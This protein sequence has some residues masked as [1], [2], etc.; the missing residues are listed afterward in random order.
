MNKKI[1]P[2]IAIA[3]ILFAASVLAFFIFKI[4]GAEAPGKTN[5]EKET[6]QKIV[7]E[8]N[9]TAENKEVFSEDLTKDWLEYKNYKYG[10]K[11]KFSRVMAV[12]DKNLDDVVISLPIASDV[13]IPFEIKI[14]PTGENYDLDTVL[15]KALAKDLEGG[16]S[17]NKEEI[18]IDGEK[19]YA[20]SS[21]GKFEC[22]TQKWAVVK[23][24]RLYLLRSIDGLPKDFELMFL[25]FRFIK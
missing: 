20:L 7:L 21:C 1:N 14:I 5:D 11:I 4:N 3:I 10:Y 2:P 22:V 8:N 24:G 15:K 19:G 16:R 12:D 23:D 9:K 17:L 18:M 6:V 13:I 25:T